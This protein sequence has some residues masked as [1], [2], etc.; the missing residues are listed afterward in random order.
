MEALKDFMAKFNNEKLTVNDEDES[1]VLAVFLEG[2]WPRRL[3]T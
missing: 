3:P 1:V 2:I